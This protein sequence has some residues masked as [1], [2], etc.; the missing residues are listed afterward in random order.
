MTIGSSDQPES[1]SGA[2]EGSSKSTGGASQTSAGG[3]THTVKDSSAGSAPAVAA[4]VTAPVE[5]PSS[6]T[7][8]SPLVV[9][10]E[11][12][13]QPLSRR[14]S[15]AERAA[16]KT[17]AEALEPRAARVALSVGLAAADRAGHRS[18]LAVAERTLRGRAR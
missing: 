4:S 10:P 2:G 17:L 8:A 7:A 18:L 16:E 3:E 12:S 15:P 1:K 13:Q 5:A 9:W 6:V 11:S 14:S